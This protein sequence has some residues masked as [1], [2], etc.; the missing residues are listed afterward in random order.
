MTPQRKATIISSLVAF[1][2]ICVKFS[3]GIL[4]GS[5]AILASAIDSMLDFCAS[6]FNFFALSKSEKPACEIFNYG[7]GK[8][9]SLACVVE[10][11]IILVSAIFIIYQ[12][13]K[14]LLINEPLAQMDLSIIIMCFSLVV[15]IA[16]VLYLNF[17][18]KKSGNLVIKADALHYKS[19][20]LSNGAVLISLLLVKFSGFSAIDGIFGLLIGAYIGYCA[21][22]LLNDGVLELLDRSLDS[23]KVEQIKQILDSNKEVISYH[24][25]KTRQSAGAN[26]V[27]VHLVLDGKISLE[28]AHNIADGIEKDIK[29]IK[30]LNQNWFVITHLDTYNDEG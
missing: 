15:T 18:A 12:S 28:S 2:L 19:D 23:N 8:I 25:L 9:E 24:H 5:I 22:T 17:I 10:G 26:F 7:R 27:E 16:L 20:I 30:D 29:A 14:K 13:I 1:M 21:I 4:S 6:A 3:A 11:S